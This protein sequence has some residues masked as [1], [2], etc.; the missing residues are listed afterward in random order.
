M[1]AMTLT[2]AYPIREIAVGEQ[3]PELRGEYLTGRRR[4]FPGRLRGAWRC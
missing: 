3:L 2:A 4:S 1:V